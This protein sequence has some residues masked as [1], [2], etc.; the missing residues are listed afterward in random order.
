MFKRIV[1]S[2]LLMAVLAAAAA[3][4]A[5]ARGGGG[6][7]SAGSG[8]FGGFGGDSG[9]RSVSASD[10]G[11]FGYSRPQ[12]ASDRNLFDQARKECNGPKYPDGA[13]P[14]VNYSANSFTCFEPGT[15]RR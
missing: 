9:G 4:P 7:G 6:S 15:S 2:G 14:R 3:V 1:A 13:T 8:G 11:S 10:R 5:T 12:T